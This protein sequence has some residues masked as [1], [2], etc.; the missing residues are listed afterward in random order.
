MTISAVRIGLI[1]PELLGTYGDRGN[2]V[3][4]QRRL[5]QHSISCELVEIASGTPLP[6]DLDIY[7]LGGGE[8]HTALL[9]AEQ[10]RGSALIPAWQRGASIVAVCAGFQLLG[11][12]IELG[13]RETLVGLGAIAAVTTVGTTRTVGDVVLNTTLAGVDPIVGF[14]NH[15]SITVTSDASPLGVA[16]SSGVA[17]GYVRDR[18]L[19]TYLHGP[20]L[21]RNPTLVDH[22]LEWTTGSLPPLPPDAHATELHRHLV[23]RFGNATPPKAR[24]AFSQRGRHAQHRNRDKGLQ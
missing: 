20:L 11:E 8:D 17:D 3:V 18:L 7:L 2:A 5:Q 23:Q 6:G 15:R 1:Y 12:T 24:G 21:V 16:R 14:E 22:V 10:L 19:A 9:A 4:L 13:T